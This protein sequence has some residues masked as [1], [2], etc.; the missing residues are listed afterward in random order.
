[1]FKH[2]H[3]QDFFSGR[4]GFSV[5]LSSL[6][7]A[8]YSCTHRTSEFLESVVTTRTITTLAYSK[9][10]IT[11]FL[12]IQLVRCPVWHS[13]NLLHHSIYGHCSQWFLCHRS[14]TCTCLEHELWTMCAGFHA[15]HTRLHVSHVYPWCHAHD[16]MCQALSLLS[17]ESPGTR[18]T[19]K[20]GEV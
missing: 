10:Q 3:F 15:A 5:L 20:L 7:S 1:M 8:I 13:E 9:Q 16:K 11:K 19:R 17:R 2:K 6:Q 4:Y 18:L 14:Y 12:I